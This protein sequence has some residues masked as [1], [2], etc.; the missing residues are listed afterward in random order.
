METSIVIHS[1]VPLD[2]SIAGDDDCHHPF[3][4]HHLDSIFECSRHSFDDHIRLAPESARVEQSFVPQLVSNP[5]CKLFSISNAASEAVHSP[6][7][8]L[9]TVFS[10]DTF[11][12]D[13]NAIIDEAPGSPPGLTASKSSKSSTNRSSSS[14]SGDGILSDVSHFED[15]GLEEEAS[16]FVKPEGKNGLVTQRQATYRATTAV[17]SLQSHSSNGPAM[18]ATRDLMNGIP[19]PGIYGPAPQL[20]LSTTNGMPLRKFSRNASTP[21]LAIRAMSN[22]NRSRSPSPQSSPPMPRPVSSGRSAARPHFPSSQTP[23][24]PV[25]RGSWQPSRKTVKELE[26]ECDDENEDFLPEEAS[27]WNVPLSPRPPSERSATL[28]PLALSPR[29]QC[30]R[31]ATLSPIPS[32]R[33]SP[34]GS[35]ERSS[36]LRTSTGAD[37]VQHTA[38]KPLSVPMTRRTLPANFQSP[39]ASPQ[40]LLRGASTGTIPHFQRSKSWNV[41]L[42]ELSEE[43]KAL[44]QS[45][46]SHA[47]ERESKDETAVQNGDINSMDKLSRAKTAPGNHLPPLR[48]NNIMID[49]LPIS[50]EKEKVLSRT[51]P[52]WLPPKSKSEE[53]KHLKEYQRMMEFSQEAERKKAAKTADTQCQKDDTKATLLR[54]WE[55]HVLPNWDRAIRE[56]RTRELW[57]RGVAPKSRGQVWSK[58]LG[59]DLALT[60]TTFKKALQRAQKIDVDLLLKPDAHRRERHW[61]DAIK[62]DVTLTFPE[63]KIFQSGAPLHDDLLDVLKAYAMYRSDVGYSHGTHL[64][65][66]FLL[67]NLATASQTFISLANLMNRPLPLAFLTGDSVGEQKAYSLTVG[68]LRKKFP[69]LAHHLFGPAPIDENNPPG[70]PASTDADISSEPSLYLSP[71]EVLE[72][73]LRTLFL[74]PGGGVGIDI[75]AR[76]WDVVVFDGDSAVIR[77]VVA[78]LGLLEG[79]LYGEREEVLGVLGWR[80]TL[81]AH[82]SP[83]SLPPLGDEDGFMRSVR[84]AGKE[85]VRRE[86]GK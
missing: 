59:N 17:A 69:R 18:A 66:A 43:A 32:P 74:G 85:A 11:G 1:I 6:Q 26:A 9:I 86:K 16:A 34:G 46:E 54:L 3:G 81:G 23:S 73:M 45:L 4:V 44:T 60:E 33:I 83:P 15:I 63:L 35:P 37:G 25:R 53:K 24:V 13:M 72:P 22:Y 30:E 41:A 64:I 51:R 79:R 61:F 56:P 62:R 5:A 8:S 36:P 68:L 40:K 31:S 21:S 42:S 65:T 70:L 71:S 67:L 57:W 80:G 48:T 7:R 77:A 50:K 39:P 19:R 10:N 76:I 55:Q 14:T 84:M 82:L 47:S 38:P 20:P 58:A 49:P 75:A 27:L 12:D 29:P 2:P 28:A 78:T 52:S